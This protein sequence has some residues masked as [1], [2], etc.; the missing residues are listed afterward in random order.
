MDLPSLEVEK[1]YK[2]AYT[3]F[4]TGG[5]ALRCK[6]F[7]QLFPLLQPEDSFEYETMK[8]DYQ[9]KE[10]VHSYLKPDVIVCDIHDYHFTLS[11]YY[12]NI[13][14]Y[15]SIFPQLKNDNLDKFFE[16]HTK[17]WKELDEIWL[18]AYSRSISARSKLDKI[19]NVA[20]ARLCGIKDL[21]RLIDTELRLHQANKPKERLRSNKKIMQY[22]NTLHDYIPIPYEIIERIN[23][24]ED[25][26]EYRV[27]V[28]YLEEE[29]GKE[30]EDFS[31]YDNT[32]RL[33]EEEFH[34]AFEDM[35]LVEIA[36]KGLRYYDDYLKKGGEDLR[37]CQEAF[38]RF[39]LYEVY[40][41]QKEFVKSLTS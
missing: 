35:K 6:L 23:T 38:D 40:A 30:V 24:V 1:V 33:L 7:M 16:I 3:N 28:H 37:K 20:Y 19:R 13:K 17:A 21:G 18:N 4:M 11:D 5:G 25:I 12:K 39:G 9:P 15:S 10:Y 2:R 34:K 8:E 41:A 32:I 14:Y 29:V 36:R 27:K 31:E 26:P 22:L